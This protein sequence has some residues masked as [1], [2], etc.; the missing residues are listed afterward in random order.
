MFGNKL[1]I[2]LHRRESLERKGNRL[3]AAMKLLEVHAPTGDEAIRAVVNRVMG[4]N[5]V[6]AIA[7]WMRKHSSSE[8][9]QQQG[10]KRL[11]KLSAQLAKAPRSCGVIPAVVM[12]M[13]AHLPSVAV[14][15]EGCGALANLAGICLWGTVADAIWEGGVDAAMYA[16]QVHPSS[17]EVQVNACLLLRLVEEEFRTQTEETHRIYLVKK[18]LAAFPEH[19]EI[20][21]HGKALLLGL[22]G[23]SS[24]SKVEDELL[25][26]RSRGESGSQGSS[27]VEEDAEEETFED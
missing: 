11:G 9:V 14:Q 24:A 17:A 10:C 25:R 13:E 1:P 6:G 8:E 7:R 16:M 15:R 23:N 2:S 18:A 19:V 20:Q 21:E 3:S 22:E 26:F 27:R 12:A 4:S 5:D